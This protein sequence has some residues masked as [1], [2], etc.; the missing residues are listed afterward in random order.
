MITENIAF[1]RRSS[2]PETV[3]VLGIQLPLH[4][5]PEV[6]RERYTILQFL[7]K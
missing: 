3:E 6:P 7:S 2:S 4:V 5:I 1:L